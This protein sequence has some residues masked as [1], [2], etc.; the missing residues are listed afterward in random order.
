MPKVQLIETPSAQ[1]IAK[2]A[3]EVT[4]TD[5]KGRVITLKKPGVLSQYRIVEV[6][7]DSAKNEVYMRMIMPLIYVTD[8]DGEAVYQPINKLQLE[9]LIQRLDEHG[10]NAVMDGVLKNFG[11]ADSEAD[12]SSIKK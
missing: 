5:A 4:V 6:A 10:V 9:A 7:A 2:A 1:I 8:I 12:K 3:A 11:Q